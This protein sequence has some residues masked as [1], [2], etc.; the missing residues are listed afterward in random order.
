MPRRYYELPKEFR[1]SEYKKFNTLAEK[2]VNV[3]EYFEK[4]FHEDYN[5][6]LIH[7]LNM[8]IDSD[9]LYYFYVTLLYFKKNALNVITNRYS[10][11][12]NQSKIPACARK[13]IS[14]QN[15]IRNRSANLNA[16]YTAMDKLL[17]AYDKCMKS[18]LAKEER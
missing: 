14:L 18:V 9:L 17:A 2:F 5:S 3:V 4:K 8:D 15:G 12:F 6:P 16:V 10:K 1:N 13:L 11:E 7:G